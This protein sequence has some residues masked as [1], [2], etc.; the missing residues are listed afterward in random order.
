MA[1]GADFDGG[2]A[3]GPFVVFDDDDDDDEDFC[4]SFVVVSG[5]MGSGSR[6]DVTGRGSVSRAF[7][8]A[9]VKSCFSLN[10]DVSMQYR[11]SSSLSSEIFSLEM[12]GRADADAGMMILFWISY[13]LMT[14]IIGIL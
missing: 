12:S 8:N 3:D 2:T 6:Y 10:P 5:M 11:S 14:M 4:L 7:F 9:D 1:C 13:V